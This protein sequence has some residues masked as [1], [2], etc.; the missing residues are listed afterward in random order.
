MH[1]CDFQFEYMLLDFN[2]AK[3][4]E[5][6]IACAIVWLHASV[7]VWLWCVHE[8]ISQIN[9]M[10]LDTSFVEIGQ[11]LQKNYN[12]FWIALNL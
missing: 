3:L 2:M 1:K 10:H 5:L 4:A 12:Y 6:S 8:C 9:G 11:K 7:F